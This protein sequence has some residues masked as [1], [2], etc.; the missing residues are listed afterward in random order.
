M[1]SMTIDEAMRRY[2]LCKR[3]YRNSKEKSWKEDMGFWHQQLLA[4]GAMGL[5]VAALPPWWA[6]G[7]DSPIWVKRRERAQERVEAMRKQGYPRH[8]L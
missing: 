8:A 7:P 3:N 1:G 5:K 4:A 2:Q 6:G